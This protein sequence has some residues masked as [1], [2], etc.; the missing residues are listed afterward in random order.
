MA[1]N[2]QLKDMHYLSIHIKPGHWLQQ[3][4]H[5]NGLNTDWKDYIW[6]NNVTDHFCLQI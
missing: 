2:L 4:K 1:S 5:F 6:L 3:L